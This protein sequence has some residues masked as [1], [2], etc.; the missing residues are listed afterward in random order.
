MAG[1]SGCWVLK[2]PSPAAGSAA[3]KVSGP[4]PRLPAFQGCPYA[5]LGDVSLWVVRAA[6]AGVDRSLAAP[7]SGACHPLPRG[8]RPHPA[9]PALPAVS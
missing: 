9:A 2:E 5:I 7:L 6:G 3:E 8:F 4:E 1:H